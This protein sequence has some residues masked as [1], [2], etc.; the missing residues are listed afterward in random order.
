MKKVDTFKAQ[1]QTPICLNGKKNRKQKC[2]I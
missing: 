2:P 1:K